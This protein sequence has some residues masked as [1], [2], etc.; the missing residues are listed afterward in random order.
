M[1]QLGL[2]AASCSALKKLPGLGQV[3]ACSF[4]EAKSLL[5]AKEGG[6]KDR[7]E[8]FGSFSRDLLTCCRM[9]CP[10]L[11]SSN[12]PVPTC[13]CFCPTWHRSLRAPKA[14]AGSLQGWG[15]LPQAV[16]ELCRKLKPPRMP[17]RLL[18]TLTAPQKLCWGISAAALSHQC[19]LC[20][21]TRCPHPAQVTPS[22]S[23]GGAAGA[24]TEQQSPL[25][26]RNLGSDI[27]TRAFPAAKQRFGHSPHSTDL[28]LLDQALLKSANT[29]QEISRADTAAGFIHISTLQ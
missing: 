18:F 7:Q 4:P 23:P 16:L 19:H 17:I 10:A 26:A 5:P 9:G 6:C 24:G 27:K 14:S 2:G 25:F 15:F 13:S 8:G 1:S 21:L 12:L 28:Y 22:P 20:C 29:L 3:G 11:R